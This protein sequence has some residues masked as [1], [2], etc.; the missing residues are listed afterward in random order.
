MHNELVTIR[1]FTLSED[2]PIVKSILDSENIYYFFKNEL[3]VQVHPGHSSALGGIQLQVRKKDAERAFS[4]LK[5]A[6]YIC[7][8]DFEPSSFEIKLYKFFS[9]I[10]LLKKIYK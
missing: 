8:E 10:P 6:G 7:Q 9:R 5:E 2:I 4:I 1:K 3:S